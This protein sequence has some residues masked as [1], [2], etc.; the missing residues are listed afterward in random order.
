[1]PRPGPSEVAGSRERPDS[2]RRV[3]THDKTFA[4]VK[5]PA[6]PEKNACR[7]WVRTS[8]TSAESPD[9]RSG[10]PASPVGSPTGALALARGTAGVVER[11]PLAPFFNLSRLSKAH[12]MHTR[13]PLFLG[14]CALATAI[15][16]GGCSGPVP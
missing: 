2:V 13:R 10:A 5:R 11:S 7:P 15:S 14:L 1:A 16:F 12:T 4:E 9:A 6:H 3:E 8:D